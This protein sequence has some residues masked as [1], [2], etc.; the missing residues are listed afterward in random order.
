MLRDALFGYPG[1]RGSSIASASS[2]ASHVQSAPAAIVPPALRSHNAVLTA[3]SDAAP[4]PLSVYARDFVAPSAQLPSQDV[5]LR[6]QRESRLSARNARVAHD[7]ERA[8]IDVDYVAPPHPAS[9]STSARGS[10]RSSA[11]SAAKPFKKAAVPALPLA[12][13]GRRAV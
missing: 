13:L 9:A 11:A 5:Q 2:V 4:N 12:R 7:R 3:H 6:A 10:A 1:T 8:A